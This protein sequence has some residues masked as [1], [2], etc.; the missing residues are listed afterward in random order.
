[1]EMLEPI[2]K[3]IFYVAIP[4]SV[5]N[6]VIEIIKKKRKSG[7]FK[8]GYLTS[9][10]PY[11]LRE[12]L[13]TPTELKFYYS[14]IESIGTEDYLVFTKVRLADLLHIK[15]R[16]DRI[17]YWNRIKSK[18][19]DFVVCDIRGKPLLCIELDDKSH[20]NP[21]SHKNDLFKDDL[22]E[23]LNIRLLRIS[24]GWKYDL[25]VINKYL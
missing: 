7:S 9:Y 17:V 16:E 8:S 19:I 20:N 21:K 10:K 4:I 14:L 15:E 5:L 25:S 3:L 24:V 22:F 1:M 13:M 23:N 6:L 2:Y 11:T 12:S 18:H